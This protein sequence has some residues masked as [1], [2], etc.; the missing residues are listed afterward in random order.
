MAGRPK[1][2]KDMLCRD[3]NSPQPELARAWKSA[4]ERGIA[5]E[6]CDRIVQVREV[7]DTLVTALCAAFAQDETLITHMKH[8]AEIQARADRK[9]R[10][11]PLAGERAA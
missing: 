4:V 10:N 7:P 8:R 9:R 1:G 3:Y 6:L 5:G 2:S 11:G